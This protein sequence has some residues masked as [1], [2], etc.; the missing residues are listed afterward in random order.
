MKMKMRPGLIA[1]GLAAAGCATTPIPGST[2]ASTPASRANAPPAFLA[3]DLNGRTVAEIDKALG[4]PDLTRIEGAG[5]FRRYALAQCA[6]LVILYPDEKGERRV[7]RL[8]VG[9]LVSGDKAPGLDDCLAA[10]KAS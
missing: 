2:S 3:G 6:L 8:D 7:T 4:T 10:G 1:L 9:A 5:E